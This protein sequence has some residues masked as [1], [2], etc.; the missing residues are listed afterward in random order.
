MAIKV[1]ESMTR[2]LAELEPREEG[3]I[4]MYACGPTVYNYVHIGNARTTL[5]YDQIRRYLTYRGFD[6]T[7]VMNYT[8]VDDRIIERSNIEGLPAPAIASKYERAFEEDMAGL[9]VTPPDI[10]SRATAHIEDMI[11]AIEGL[12]ARGM[13]YEADG[14]VFFAVEKFAGY[15]KLSGRSLDELNSRERVEPHPSKNHPLDF[16]LW[17]TAKPGEPSWQSPWGAGRPG[18][19]IECSVMSTKYLGM[20]FDI[21]GGGMDL[22]FPHHENELAQAEGLTGDEPFVRYWLHTGLVQMD[23]EKMS[24]SLGNVRL[25]HDLLE[26]YPGEVL[27]YWALSGS[28]RAQA[29]LSDETLRDAH[30]SFERW[31]TFHEAARHLLGA[32]APQRNDRVRPIEEAIDNEYVERFV[33]AMDDDFNSA[34]AFAVIHDVVGEG[35]KQLDAAQRGDDSAKTQVVEL[36]SVFLELTGVL[37]FTFAGADGSS[38]LVGGLV[39]YLLQL[40]E[41]ARAEK[42]FDTADGIRDHLI[43][44]GVAVEDT[45]AGPRWRLS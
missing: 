27:R 25:A 41:E 3:R 31:K 11:E 4:A 6:V 10:L 26:S 43:A 21:H 39:E 19:H 42:R 29:I 36:F 40:R 32:D 14:N 23:S 44:L 34:G 12:V 37:N 22:I 9:G 15:G 18:W 35:N 33:A 20:S 17:K 45:P 5:W 24:K 7:Y 13:A 16:A 8:D 30:Q 38:E 2:K 1:Y 28:Y